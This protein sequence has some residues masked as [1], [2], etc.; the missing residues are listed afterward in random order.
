MEAVFLVV[1]FV[2]QMSLLLLAAHLFQSDTQS[3]PQIKL[4]TKNK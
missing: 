2:L 4:R 1:E 3:H